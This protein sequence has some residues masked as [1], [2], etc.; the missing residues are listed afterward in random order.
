MS[1]QGLP[2]QA[3]SLF[4]PQFHARW[5]DREGALSRDYGVTAKEGETLTYMYTNTD[6]DDRISYEAQEDR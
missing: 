2:P 4:Q 3:T 1:F 5:L 6:V